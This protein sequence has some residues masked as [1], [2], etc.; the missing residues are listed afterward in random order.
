MCS[1][2]G[3]WLLPILRASGKVLQRKKEMKRVDLAPNTE[4][5]GTSALGKGSSMT[6][7]FHQSFY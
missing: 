1:Q 6:A 2:Q 4:I 7:I 3:L 5:L